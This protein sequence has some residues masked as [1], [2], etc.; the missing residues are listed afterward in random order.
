MID[1]DRY[2]LT[3]LIGKATLPSH[4]NGFLK[5]VIQHGIEI[6]FKDY[7]K[8][9][10]AY[11]S[12]ISNLVNEYHIDLPLRTFRSVGGVA[13]GWTKIT[14][15]R[16][17]KFT[18]WESEG[19]IM[20]YSAV[21]EINKKRSA[22]LGSLPTSKSLYL[23]GFILPG[24]DGEFWEPLRLYPLIE[25]I[26]KWTNTTELEHIQKRIDHFQPENN[27]TWERY[28]FNCLARNILCAWFINHNWEV[29]QITTEPETTEHVIEPIKGLFTGKGYKWDQITISE[30][31]GH[32]IRIKAPDF[33]KQYHYIELGMRNK[34]N[35]N[36]TKQWEEFYKIIHG[37]G[38]F[39][40]PFKGQGITE[41]RI[42]RLNKKL[43]EITGIDDNPI[44][45]IKAGS[46]KIY[47]AKFHVKDEGPPFNQLIQD[48]ERDMSKY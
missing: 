9:Q 27:I 43:I 21:K 34:N 18:D 45:K 29:P 32:T 46:I 47:R 3:L 41:Q 42:S 15:D 1:I 17:G 36:S 28:Q 11:S 5:E 44:I 25:E 48:Q 14:Y 40:L 19:L 10:A 24:S 20:D 30:I 16:N 8:K 37:G 7:M 33:V 6:S 35:D 2:F 38:H 13:E 4:R 26:L 31:D 23:P 22:L 12:H 39:E